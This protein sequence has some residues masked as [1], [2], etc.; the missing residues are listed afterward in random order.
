[1][2]TTTHR[3]TGAATGL[4][5]AVGT[6][7]PPGQALISMTVATVTSG[8]AT[9]PDIDLRGGWR[10]V[11]KLLPDEYAG[12]GGPFRH[13]GL[14]HWWGVPALVAWWGLPLVPDSWHWVATAALLGWVSHLVGDFFFGKANRPQGRGPGI[15][16]APWWGHIG[17]GLD[18]GGRVEE[19][20]RWLALPALLAW[21][22]AT[23]VLD[24]GWIP[25][26]AWGG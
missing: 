22:G 23:F 17:L 2:L 18:A 10:F 1:M 12:H 6:G 13:R 16:V 8:G 3:L 19:L 26:S 14:A 15:P 24:Q 7:Q 4:A 20:F 25:T 5:F 21:Q 11:D 9:S